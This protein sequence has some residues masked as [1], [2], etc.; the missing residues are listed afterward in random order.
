MSTSVTIITGTVPF[1]GGVFPSGTGFIVL[2][3]VECIGTETALDNCPSG[4]GS[5]CRHSEDAGVRCLGKVSD[6]FSSLLKD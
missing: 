3:D 5:S 4:D 6:P 1:A 2:A